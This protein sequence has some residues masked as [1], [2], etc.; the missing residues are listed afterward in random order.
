MRAKLENKGPAKVWLIEDDPAV[1]K[2]VAN[3]LADLAGYA[4]TGVS[5]SAEDALPEIGSNPSIKIVL[6]DLRL[7]KMT[8]WEC[9]RR[10][11]A[12]KSPPRIIFL[13]GVHESAA[14]ATAIGLHCSYVTKPFGREELVEA[15]QAARHDSVYLS[16]AAA[17]LVERR[18][19]PFGPPKPYPAELWARLTE[20][21]K[22]VLALSAGGLTDKAVADLL[23]RSIHTVKNLLTAIRGKL[24]VDSTKE[25]IH[26]TCCQAAEEKSPPASSSSSTAPARAG[27]RTGPAASAAE[28]GPKAG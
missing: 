5:A 14:V 3:A 17:K 25:A 16:P 10:L 1:A 9:A 21:E 20:W 23:P 6:L 26:V 22:Q 2:V 8:G 4:L 28:G 12:A 11:K 24:D 7:P 18:E 27:K 13:S 19:N 15:L